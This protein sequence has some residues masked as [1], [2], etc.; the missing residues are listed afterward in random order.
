MSLVDGFDAWAASAGVQGA[1]RDQYMMGE[2]L[3]VAPMF[4]GQASRKVV[5][6]PGEWFDFYS[7]DPVGG[8][9]TIEVAPGLERIPLFVRDG[10]IIPLIPARRHAP[11][12]GEILPLEIRHYGRSGGRFELYDDDGTTFGFERGEYSWTPLTMSRDA[13]GHLRGSM[14]VPPRG[15]P[16]GYAKDPVWRVM[17]K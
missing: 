8:G 12:A 14:A 5:L 10:G 15:K 9:R 2:T 7:G 6:P 4:A 1:V 17:T 3:L 11:A 16:F 13:A